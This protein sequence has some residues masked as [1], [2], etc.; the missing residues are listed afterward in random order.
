MFS[1]ERE[2]NIAFE[3]IYRSYFPKLKSFAVE[4]VVLEE[5][6]E[7]IIQ[8][9]FADLWERREMLAMDTGLMALLFTSVKNRCL[10]HL[11]HVAIQKKYTDQL[12]EE[13]LL[14]FRMN[15]ESL[16]AFNQHLFSEPEIDKII[17]RAICSLPEKCRR[18]FIMSKIDNKKQKE[19][20][21]ELQLS[22]NT[23][24]SQMAIAYRKLK[25]KLKNY[26]PLYLFLLLF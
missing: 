19:I 1:V 4:Y 8:D 17:D 2:K 25:E 13:F 9:V 6:A 20:A 26:L 11:K 14:M 5:D 12:Q 10:N 3:K 16:E 22:V 15:F 24:E 21:A 18:I 7:N 23:V